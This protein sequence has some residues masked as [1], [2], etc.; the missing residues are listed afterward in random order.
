VDRLRVR[1]RRLHCPLRSVAVRTLWQSAFSFVDVYL[2]DR[3]LGGAPSTESAYLP[4]TQPSVMSND[5]DQ[6]ALTARSRYITLRWSYV[7]LRH[8]PGTF[9]LFVCDHARKFEPDVGGPCLAAWQNGPPP[10]LAAE[11]DWCHWS[12]NQL[13]NAMVCTMV[14]CCVAVGD[15]NLTFTAF[16]WVIRLPLLLCAL[17]GGPTVGYYNTLRPVAQKYT[18]SIS[19][20]TKNQLNAILSHPRTFTQY[21]DSHTF[22]DAGHLYSP[23]CGWVN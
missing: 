6:W 21:D 1:R 8:A 5:R 12:V 14:D 15:I 16:R 7:T 19:K 9:N 17:V 23:L 22:W 20:R 3:S 13:Y 2:L 11:T 4:S 10:C 18:N